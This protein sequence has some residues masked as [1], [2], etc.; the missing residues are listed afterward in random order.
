MTVAPVAVSA[1]LLGLPC[2]YDGDAR[3]SGDVLRALRGRAALPV[4]PETAAGLGVPRPSFCF[5]HADTESILRGRTGLP[6][7]AG[8][9]VAPVLVATCEMLAERVCAAGTREAILKSRSPSCGVHRVYVGE[10]LVPGRGA[11]ARALG[12]RGV[13]VRSDEDPPSSVGTGEGGGA[14]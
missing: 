13:A 9:D 5:A 10:E 12:L 14:G 4:C 7:E 11:F 6:D 3:P 1:C 8:V 2:R